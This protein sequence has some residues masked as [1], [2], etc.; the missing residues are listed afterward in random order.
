MCVEYHFLSLRL[1]H[2]G[3]PPILALLPTFMHADS[4]DEDPI[5]WRWTIGC[6]LDSRSSVLCFVKSGRVW[7]S[8]LTSVIGC[9]DHE[10]DIYVY[11]PRESYKE[12][13][14]IIASL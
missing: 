7:L 1:H 12:E 5:S 6:Y 11:I 13:T 8:W 3:F 4:V 14:K 9:M 2:G 10:A